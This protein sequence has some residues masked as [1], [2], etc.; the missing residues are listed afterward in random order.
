MADEDLEENQGAR[1]DKKFYIKEKTKKL[2]AKK[3]AY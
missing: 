1:I 2:R 3:A